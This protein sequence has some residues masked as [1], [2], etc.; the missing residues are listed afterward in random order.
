MEIEQQIRENEL[1]GD[2]FHCIQFVAYPHTYIYA[3]LCSTYYFTPSVHTYT[4]KN[5]RIAGYT[6]MKFGMVNFMIKR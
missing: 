6:F 1:S 3:M 2:R 4:R 5:F